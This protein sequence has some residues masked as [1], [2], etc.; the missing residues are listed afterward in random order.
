MLSV[1]SAAGEVKSITAVGFGSIY[2]GDR[3]MARDAAVSDAMRNAVEEAVGV[4]VA[5]ETVVAEFEL[6]SDRIYS[7]SAGYIRSY[8]VVSEGVDDEKGLYRV[9]IAA[10]VALGEIR[11]DLAAI[12]ILLA[13]KHMPRMMVVM[14]ED[15][16]SGPSSP[17][18]L[19][20]AET[21]IMDAFTAKGFSFVDADTAKREAS[22]IAS[23]SGASGEKEAAA[24]AARL[25]AEVI[26]VGKAVARPADR[27]VAGT[28]LRSVQAT[29][30][31][32]ALAADTGAVIASASESGAAV[33]LDPT[34]G[35]AEAVKKTS[36]RLAA[37]LMD[38]ILA[39]WSREV[40]TSQTVKLVFKGVDFRTLREIRT[41]LEREVR[42]VKAVHQRS[43][44]GG[45]GV[46]DVDGE[47]DAQ[48][49]AD[50]LT[51]KEIDG[52]TLEV[53]AF[54]SGSVELEAAKRGGPARRNP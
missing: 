9:K 43:Y 14:E 30:T 45:V 15:L 50:R 6:L 54:S 27:K 3:A 12:G 26:I 19:N 36:A 39:R 22:R 46:L 41:F 11:D 47:T 35:G 33:H 2:K 28:N 7:R 34:A 40:Q 29:V 16:G 53:T 42:G 37:A 13:R 10:E 24:L 44:S 32:R 31:A 49:L 38:R 52:I 18:S 1:A 5:S 48:G 51:A 8:R 20:Q 23:L 4:L 21:T 25:G 17:G